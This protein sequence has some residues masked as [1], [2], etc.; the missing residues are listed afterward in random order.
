MVGTS[1]DE[2]EAARNAARMEQDKFDTTSRGRPGQRT[3]AADEQTEGDERWLIRAWRAEQLHRLGLSWLIAQTFAPLVD[4]H[5]V[6]GLV[7]LGCSP[8]LALEIVL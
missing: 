2:R 5:E 6:A 7:E 8:E 3:E 1:E 4:W